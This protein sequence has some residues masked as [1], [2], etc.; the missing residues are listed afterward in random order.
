MSLTQI[1]SSLDVLPATDRAQIAAWLLQTLPEHEEEDAIDESVALARQREAEL[2]RGEAQE[3]GWDE[4]WT[5]VR[6]PANP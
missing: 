6:E 5:Q 4:F 2:D 1:R 3:V